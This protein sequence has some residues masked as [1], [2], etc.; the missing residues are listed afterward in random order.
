VVVLDPLFRVQ[1]C[2][3]FLRVAELQHLVMV[4]CVTWFFVSRVLLFFIVGSFVVLRRV[5]YLPLPL[6]SCQDSR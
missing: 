5:H 2:S 6:S 1:Y 4:S 3:Q